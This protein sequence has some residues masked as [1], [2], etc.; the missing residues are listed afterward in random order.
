LRP[1]DLLLCGLLAAWFGVSAVAQL[2]GVWARRI[3]AWD[4]FGVI[5][6]WSFF[7]PTPGRTDPHLLYRDRLADGALTSWTEIPLIE[8]RRWQH[9]VWNP[10]RRDKKA[11]F[12]VVQ[13]LNLQFQQT[14]P[15]AIVLTIP[16]LLL[17]NHVS[18]LPRPAV[19]VGTQFML[20][21]SH[22]F[23]SAERPERRMLSSWHSL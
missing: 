16:Y 2:P 10:L 9:V 13:L 4:S 20:V 18:G 11:L 19:C 3:R 23:G 12:D 17:L 22:G 7:A 5:P 14:A 1:L 15:E 8:P 21:E 6:H